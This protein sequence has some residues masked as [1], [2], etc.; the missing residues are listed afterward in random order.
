MPE[1]LS[2]STP[3]WEKPNSSSGMMLRGSDRIRVSRISAA[4]GGTSAAAASRRARRTPGSAAARGGGGA[5]IRRAARSGGG[6]RGGGGAVA[7]GRW[8]DLGFGVV[9]ERHVGRGG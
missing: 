8:W 9:G 4:A 1:T 3:E 5:A 7:R 6:G 2:S